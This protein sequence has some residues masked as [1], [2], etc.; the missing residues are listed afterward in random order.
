MSTIQPIAQGG[1]APQRLHE[2]VYLDVQA[3]I[4]DRSLIAGDRLPSEHELSRLSGV[5][6]PIVR[7]AL[8][9]L[10]ADGL[11][12]S[13]RGAGAF[14]R[15][16]PFGPMTQHLVPA[17]LRLRL[18]TLEVR[19]ALEPVAARLAAQ[20]ASKLE[21]AAIVA[22][23]VP[24]E[25]LSGIGFHLAIAAASHN[26]MFELVLQNLRVKLDDASASMPASGL[27]DESVN[28]AGEEHGMIAAAIVRREPEVAEFAMRLH[29][30]RSRCRILAGL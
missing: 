24:G 2:R 17:P 13:R 26:P 9:R 6:R 12:E 16:A 8:K 30:L 5:S 18:S 20:N 23:S 11:I 7:E 29:L 19:I 22:A 21:R 27:R 3:L 4:A 1:G 25:I 28:G 14:V 10:Q 15:R